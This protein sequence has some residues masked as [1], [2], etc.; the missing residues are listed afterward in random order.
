MGQG[1]H[2]V[3]AQMHMELDTVEIELAGHALIQ[4]LPEE[5][6]EQ[7]DFIKRQRESHALPSPPS[8]ASRKDSPSASPRASVD[9]SL[10]GARCTASRPG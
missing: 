7:V 1:K 3:S 5:T 4:E 6:P 10:R 2:A 9:G 8:W